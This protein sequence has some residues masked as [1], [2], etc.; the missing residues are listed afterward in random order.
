MKRFL[1]GALVL[2]NLCAPAFALE[3]Q[4]DFNPAISVILDG[5]Y[6]HDDTDGEGLE[7]LEA[8]E[9]I[10]G[11]HGHG[12]EHGHGGLVR[13]FNLRE[14]ELTLS[15][16]VDPYF[17]AWL[18]AAFGEEGVELEEAWVRT[19]ALPHGLQLKGGRFLSAVGYH[20]EKHLHSWNFTDQNLAYRSLF[21][22]HGLRGNGLQATWLAP[23]ANFLKIGVEALQG[24]ELERF[25][26]GID[27][28]ETAELIATEAGLSE[29]PELGLDDKAGPGLGMAWVRF[30]PALGAGQGLQLGLSIARHRDSQSLHEE[31]GTPP[32]FVVT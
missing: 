10:F 30:G 17:D 27:A 8:V 13:G 1:F 2:S 12:E 26:A 11:G 21:G 5:V 15:G 14:T 7:R 32:D 28:G 23:T 3:D 19:Q 16:N 20:N 9:S 31:E 24:N 18:T 25:G 22:D 29:E 4:R 6:Y